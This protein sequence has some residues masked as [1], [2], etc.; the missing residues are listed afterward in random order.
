MV[1]PAF[2]PDEE[3]LSWEEIRQQF[4][5]ARKVRRA[6]DQDAPKKE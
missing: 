4:A 3:P 6:G 5:E 2:Y 1:A